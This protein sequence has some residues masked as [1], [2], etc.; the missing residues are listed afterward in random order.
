MKARGYR[1]L[2]F[3]LWLPDADMAVARVARR[4]EEGGHD[5]P[6]EDVRR[7]YQAGS[8]NLYRLYR[9]I[10]DGWWLY[11]ASQLPPRLIAT[12]EDGQLIVNRKRL[13]RRI[14]QQTDEHHEESN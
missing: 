9:P 2:L 10:L 5:V 4:V 13:Y 8:K 6:S 14:E 11:D 7:R 12:L 1:I 3:F